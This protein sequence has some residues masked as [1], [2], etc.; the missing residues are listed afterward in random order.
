MLCLFSKCRFKRCS[1]NFD[2]GS[3]VYDKVKIIILRLNIFSFDKVTMPSRIFVI[4]N[5]QTKID[6]LFR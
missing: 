3:I 4:P 6:I 5:M 2:V 1:T